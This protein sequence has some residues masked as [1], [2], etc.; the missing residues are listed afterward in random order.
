M[1]SLSKAWIG[2]KISRISPTGRVFFSTSFSIW[3]EIKYTRTT[4]STRAL[5]IQHSLFMKKRNFKKVICSQTSGISTF[6]RPADVHHPTIGHGSLFASEI[7]RIWSGTMDG[8]VLLVAFRVIG[9][10]NY[11]AKPC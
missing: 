2:S 6:F 3:M 1:K 5:Q 7:D 11:L 9:I 10:E 8:T 4:Y